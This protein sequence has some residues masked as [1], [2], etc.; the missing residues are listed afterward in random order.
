MFLISGGIG[1]CN[2][3]RR[4]ILS[5][6][7]SWAPHKLTIRVNTSCLTDEFLAHRIGQLSFRKIGNGTTMELVTDKAVVTANDLTG[8]SFEASHPESEIVFLHPSQ[9]ID[10]TIHFDEQPPSKHVRYATCAA[11]GMIKKGKH[12]CLVFELNDNSSCRDMLERAFDV[13]DVMIDTALQELAHQ[14]TEPPHSLC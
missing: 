4:V 8:P 13:M 7:P 9:E 2:A 1:F 10:C 6:V 11:V 12:H 14:P 5:D 3:I